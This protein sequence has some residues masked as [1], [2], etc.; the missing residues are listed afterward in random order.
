MIEKVKCVVSQSELDFWGI[1]LT[2]GAEYEVIRIAG[3]GESVWI[4]NDVGQPE[5]LEVGGYCQVETDDEA[6]SMEA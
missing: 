5:F 2:C 6:C 4:E 3:D 1:W